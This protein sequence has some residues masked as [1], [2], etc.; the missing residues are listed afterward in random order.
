MGDKPHLMLLD[1]MAYTN[2]LQ[3]AKFSM[4][5]VMAQ[6]TCEWL[7]SVAYVHQY[8]GLTGGE[9]LS[10]MDMVHYLT[11]QNLADPDKQLGAFF[12]QL[13]EESAFKKEAKQLLVL[14]VHAHSLRAFSVTIA[15]ATALALVPISNQT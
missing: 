11:V 7:R 5:E 12:K 15:L 13:D 9:D 4:L 2:K 8:Q 10:E 6:W 14:Y 1:A 3:G